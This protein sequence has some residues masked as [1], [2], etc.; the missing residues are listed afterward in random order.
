MKKLVISKSRLEKFVDAGL[1]YD[2]IAKKLSCSLHTVDN[3]FRETGARR[4]KPRTKTWIKKDELQ[5]RIAA[6]KT[7]AELAKEFRCCVSTI[8]RLC[9][10]YG[11]ALPVI[12]HARLRKKTFDTRFFK[13][14]NTE[15]KAYILGF[16]S[17]DGGRDRNWG[18]K[19]SLHPKD[20]EL[21][22]RFSEILKCNYKPV[23]V[24]NGTRVKLSLYDVDM[25]KDLEKYGVVERKTFTLP[26]AKNV[27]ENLIRH[28]LR[29]MF[30]GDG[31]FSRRNGQAHFVCGSESFVNG[32]LSWAKK[33]YGY[34][35]WSKKEGGKTRI[36]IRKREAPMVRDMYGDATIYLSRKKKLYDEFWSSNDIV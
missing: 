29:G 34:A 16:I 17:A 33:T 24:E 20:S 5:K 30:D 3:K 19:I 2:E 7:S 15:Q 12:K 21:L 31:S 23:L 8:D 26:F 25:V 35:L 28:Y 14:I 4:P 10:R 6:G 18:I 9:H 13:T 11:I 36:A 27:P 22:Y 1:R 32:L